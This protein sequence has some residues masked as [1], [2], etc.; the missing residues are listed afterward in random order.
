MNKN[1]KAHKS[2]NFLRV[3]FR[4]HKAQIQMT[5][6]IAVLFI[7]FVLILFGIVFYYKYSQIS[8]KEK[9]EELL[10]ARAMEIT[11]KTLF[12]P[13]LVCSQG[14]A[15]LE[16][17]C[18][19]MM[20]LRQVND[21]FANNF[22]DY[23][24]YLFPYTK[25]SIQEIYPGNQTWNIYEKEKPDWESMERTYFVVTLKDEIKGEQQQG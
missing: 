9:Q 22:G 3:W 16:D 24:F 7:F 17:N 6:T 14:E 19:D 18:F 25:I 15:E 12:L 8:F 10:G 20:K 23:Y 13:E 1:R 4:E 11:L 21:T 2:T 5:E